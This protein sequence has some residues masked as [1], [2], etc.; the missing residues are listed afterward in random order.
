MVESLIRQAVQLFSNLPPCKSNK[1]NPTLMTTLLRDSRLAPYPLL[2]R[3]RGTGARSAEK[4][5]AGE[6]TAQQRLKKRFVDRST[7]AFPSPFQPMAPQQQRQ[8]GSH[9]IRHAA[10]LSMRQKPGGASLTPLGTAENTTPLYF[11]VSCDVRCDR[12]STF[13]PIFF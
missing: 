7:P 4:R 3:T 6:R 12:G 10:T 5:L 8:P 9:S 13:W 11:Q 1:Q 2:P